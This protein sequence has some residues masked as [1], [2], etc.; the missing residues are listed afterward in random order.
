MD[1]GNAQI[2]NDIQ[3]LQDV[4]KS[5]HKEVLSSGTS[6]EEAL[7][8]INELSSMRQTLYKSL[9]NSY[10]NKA[11]EVGDDG[12]DIY[13]QY[14]TSQI[15]EDELNNARKKLSAAKKDRYDTE[16]KMEMNTYYEKQNNA[17][18]QILKNIVFYCVCL[19]VTVAI[20][21][22][23]ILPSILVK[24]IIITILG[25]GFTTTLYK[26]W[27]YMVRDNMNFDEYNWYWTNNPE[28]KSIYEYDKEQLEQWFGGVS[29][30]VDNAANQLY[31]DVS[32]LG[33]CI[34]Q[35]C[36]A[37]GTYYDSTQNKCV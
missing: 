5:I 37:D 21:K 10:N 1:S 36:C 31:E 32:S 23:K 33:Q 9:N 18:I 2:L 30:E 11:I 6:Q 17:K 29:E 16:K 20:Y 25:F 34:G 24:M 22:S 15:V 26:I 14:T 19:L 3:N 8:R 13:N 35:S 28:Q 12:I 27:D 7:R 4:E